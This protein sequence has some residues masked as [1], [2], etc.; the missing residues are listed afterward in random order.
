MEKIEIIIDNYSQA[1]KNAALVA[2]LKSEDSTLIELALKLNPD[3]FAGGGEL[4]KYAIKN[5]NFELLGELLQNPEITENKELMDEGV[6]IAVSLTRT[7]WY[8]VL[9]DLIA[10]GASCDVA[11]FELLKNDNPSIDVIIGLLKLGGKAYFYPMHLEKNQLIAE[12]LFKKGYGK[13]VEFSRV[14][15][16]QFCYTVCKN[17]KQ[18]VV[19]KLIKDRPEWIAIL[20]ECAVKNGFTAIV[21]LLYQEKAITTIDDK[22]F[23]K[24]IRGKHYFTVK[25]LAETGIRE[26][27]FTDVIT[28]AV[29]G[30]VKMMFL[31]IE[32]IKLQG[33]NL[34]T[35]QF[36]TLIKVACWSN[37][38]DS[39]EALLKAGY[40]CDFDANIKKVA[41]DGRTK[42]VQ[43]LMKYATKLNNIS[44]D[45]A[46]NCAISNKW[47]HTASKMR[48]YRR[49]NPQKFE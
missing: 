26:L 3:I 34:S 18:G 48:D 42:M 39:V 38:K 4:F 29:F 37:R 21:R 7:E 23:E 36:A 44:F 10:D 17:N 41:G 27:E 49:R 28:A 25:Y 1:E 6:R 12:I 24:T 11:V 32:Q 45:E 5:C 47:V 20:T 22:L 46:I 9:A 14:A 16:E 35:D 33:K 30:T 13:S 2:A 8:Q 31:F 40:K 19:K 43:I 15:L